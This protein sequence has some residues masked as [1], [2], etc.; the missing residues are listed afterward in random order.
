M[1]TNASSTYQVFS[2]DS[3]LISSVS[4]PS[5]DFTKGRQ[6]SPTNPIT[7][8]A[9]KS[10]QANAIIYFFQRYQVMELS[11]ITLQTINSFRVLIGTN[12]TVLTASLVSTT[13]GSYQYVITVPP[14]LT[15]PAKR[16]AAVISISETTNITGFTIKACTGNSFFLVNIEIILPPYLIMPLTVS[17]L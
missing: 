17:I 4:P 11:L 1:C 3:P 14:A 12:T 7:L 13:D 6:I 5:S 2:L 15:Q 8:S 16:V 10:T 9:G